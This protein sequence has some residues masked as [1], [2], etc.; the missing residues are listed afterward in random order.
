MH[1]TVYPSSEN[2]LFGKD[3]PTAPLPRWNGSI[4][5]G[6]L[7]AA[8]LLSAI[9]GCAGHAT[10][11]SEGEGSPDEKEKL[12]VRAVAAEKRTIATSVF[13][14]G[15]V[16]ALPKRIATLTPAVE[17]R[18]ASILARHGDTVK[19]GQVLVQLDPTIAQASVAEKAAARDGLEA[20]LRLLESLPR[21]EEQQTAKVAIEQAKV[22]VAKERAIVDRLR[23]LRAKNE[24]P[25]GQMFEAEQALRQAIL[26][27]QTTEAQYT[28]LMLRP[29]PQA[30]EEAKKKITSAE[31][32]VNSAKAQLELH[33][34]R[35]PIDGMMDS[36][37]CRLGQTLAVGSPIGEVVD[38]RQVDLVVWLPV[39]EALRLRAGQAA[40]VTIGGP[41]KASA[42]SNEDDKTIQGQVTFVGRVADPQTGNLPVRILVE[43]PQGRLVLGQVASAAIA[44]EEKSVLAVPLE[45]IQ[46]IGEGPVLNVIREGKSAVLKPQLGM[47]DKHWVEVQ[48][49]DLRPGELVI[50]EGG[51]NLPE[52]TEVTV[53]SEKE[54]HDHAEKPAAGEKP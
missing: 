13:G 34:I 40:R 30:I 44:V 52:K 22:A 37:T 25:E 39:P 54:G 24:I 50:V 47:R 1:T 4:P 43:N 36:L 41:E 8:M 51:Y 5:L 23:P 19:A 28:V 46:D 16:E 15:R 21:T 38:S 9:A 6:F 42:G 3:S 10:A 18:V 12:A 17:G 49:S 48:G 31:A 53:E 2:G 32:A 14:L 20:S 45:A 29:R 7:L 33:A 26:Q 11:T 27:Q 35:S